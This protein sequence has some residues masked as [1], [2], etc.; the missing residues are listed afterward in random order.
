MKILMKH[1]FHEPGYHISYLPYLPY[2]YNYTNSSVFIKRKHEPNTA[3]AKR[4][5]DDDV[6]LAQ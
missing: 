2:L 3:K 4:Y 5:L 6:T 1:T